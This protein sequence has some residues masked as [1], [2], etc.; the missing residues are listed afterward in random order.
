MAIGTDKLDALYRK[1]KP[2]GVTMTALLAKACGVALMQH[3]LLYSSK[4]PAHPLPLLMLRLR[5][6]LGCCCGGGGGNVWDAA[7]TA[8]CS[9]ATAACSACSA[10]KAVLFLPGWGVASCCRRVW[11]VAAWLVRLLWLWWLLCLDVLC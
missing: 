8:V 7:A 2:K 5:E 6:R 3:P 9:A 1:L 10:A 11:G 4:W